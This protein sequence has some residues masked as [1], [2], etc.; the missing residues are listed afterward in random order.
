M[1]VLVLISYLLNLM[2][3]S[4]KML[5]NMIYQ[6]TQVKLLRASFKYRIIDNLSEEEHLFKYICKQFQ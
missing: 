6:I 4:I 1:M 2:G 3:I 5:S